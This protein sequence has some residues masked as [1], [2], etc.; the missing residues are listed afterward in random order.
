VSLGQEI[1]RRRKVAGKTL[2][3]LAEAAGISPHYLSTLETGKRDPSVSMVTKVAKAL[4]VA[5]GELLGT[6]KGV[7]PEAMEAARLFD[8]VGKDVKAGVMLILRASPRKKKA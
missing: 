7:S 1:R 4:G 3:G 5:P 2:E 6:A 8:G